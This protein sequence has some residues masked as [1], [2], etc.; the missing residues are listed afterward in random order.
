MTDNLFANDAYT[1][2]DVLLL[3][4]FSE[5]LPGEVSLRTRLVR[6]VW[7]N[8]PVVS[9]AMDTVTEA[10]LAIALA[11]EGG[12]GVIHRNMSVAQQAAEVD[13]VKRSEAGMITN[14]ITLH[15]HHTLAAAELIMGKYHISGIP[16]TAP[17]E[18]GKLVGILTNRGYPLQQRPQPAHRRFYDERA[19][20]HRRG[21][22][23]PGR[24]PADF[25]E[26]P[27][28]KAAAGG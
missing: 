27:H 15:P 7:L 14:P 19:G 22:Q 25:A 10:R 26:T 5:V 4:Q 12:I 3:P 23:H 20:H 16:S 17:D 18:S 13:Q 8:V 11:R 21:G 6:E 1:F 28:R 24:S 2:D 9:A